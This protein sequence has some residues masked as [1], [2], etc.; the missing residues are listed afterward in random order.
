MADVNLSS[1]PASETEALAML[2]MQNQDLHGKTP[3][4]LQ[5][6]YYETYYTLLKDWY[7]KHDSGWFRA[8]KDSARSRT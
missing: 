5:A 4:E 3:E 2:Y 8:M 6:M 1:F 7:K